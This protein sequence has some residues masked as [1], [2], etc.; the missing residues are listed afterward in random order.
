ML[1]RSRRVIAAAVAALGLGIGSAVVASSS[2]SAAPA[3]IPECSSAN[4]AVWI[5]P[6][7]ADGAAGTIYYPLDF[8]NTSNHTCYL[9][10]WPGVSAVNGNVKQLGAAAVRDT[11]I[12]RRVVNVAPGGTAH[13]TLLYVDAVVFNPGCVRVTASYLNVYPPDQRSARIAFFDNAVCTVK[14]RTYLRIRRIQPGVG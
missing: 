7:L 9:V 5:S 12:P 8:T 14:A 3:A 1:F 10:G 2:A 13:A 4:L 11:T 6:E